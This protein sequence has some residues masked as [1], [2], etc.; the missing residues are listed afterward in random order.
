MDMIEWMTNPNGW[1]L[2][3]G[4]PN[5]EG[6][7]KLCDSCLWRNHARDWFISAASLKMY[8][9]KPDFSTFLSAAP[10]SYRMEA[11]RTKNILVAVK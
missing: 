3:Y 9:K 10:L 5:E 4:S 8:Y 11:R 2:H 1:T 6:S 7:D